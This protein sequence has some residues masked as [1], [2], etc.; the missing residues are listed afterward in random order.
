MD[1]IELHLADYQMQGVTSKV[2][3]MSF[4]DSSSTVPTTKVSLRSP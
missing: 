4:F 1:H 3:R 2:V